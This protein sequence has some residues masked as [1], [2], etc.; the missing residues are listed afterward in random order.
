MIPENE[1]KNKFLALKLMAQANILRN[2][3]FDK[4]YFPG[5]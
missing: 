1:G 2:I 3:E 4:I 5:R